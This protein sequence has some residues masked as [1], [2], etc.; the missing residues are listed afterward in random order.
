[1]ITRDS[2]HA[3]AAWL[4]LNECIST[5]GQT[6]MSAS[7]GRG[8]PSRLSAW[9]AYLGSKFAPA[10]AKNVEEAMSQGIGTHDILDQPT[11]SRVTQA[12]GPIWD[13]VVAG[14][15]SVKDALNDVF[16]AVD[17]IIAENRK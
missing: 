5:A 16:A 8:S 12:A 13:L 10:G 7:T 1:M 6:Y 17:P 2:K 14:Q 4:Y 15:K 3:D 9:P 11:S